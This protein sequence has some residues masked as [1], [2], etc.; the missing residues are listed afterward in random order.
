VGSDPGSGRVKHG[1]LV[2]GEGALRISCGQV[3]RSDRL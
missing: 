2:L 1:M 3:L